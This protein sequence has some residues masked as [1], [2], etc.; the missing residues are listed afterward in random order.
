MKLKDFTYAV[1]RGLE[2]T[3]KDYLSSI[4]SVKHSIMNADRAF[5]N[6]FNHKAKFPKWKKKSNSDVKMYFV[7]NGVKQP[8]LCERH[9][10][11]IPTFGWVRLKEKGSDKSGNAYHKKRFCFYEGRQMFLF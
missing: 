11:K 1:E 4:K 10:I 9:K 2:I 6:F 3:S 5:R 8:I 7:R